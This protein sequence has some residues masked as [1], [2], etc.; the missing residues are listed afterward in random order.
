MDELELA[1]RGNLAH[2]SDEDQD[3][4]RQVLNRLARRNAHFHIQDLK[5]LVGP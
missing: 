3:S 4:L 5:E 1:F 2:L